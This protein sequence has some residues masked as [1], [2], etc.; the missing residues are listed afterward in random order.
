MKRVFLIALAA[1]S[2]E[3]RDGVITGNPDATVDLALIHYTSDAPFE[4]GADVLI[5]GTPGAVAPPGGRVRLTPPVGEAVEVTPNAAGG[6]VAIVWATLGDSL[7]ITYEHAD[8]EAEATL[9]LANDVRFVGVSAMDPLVPEPPVDGIV[10][11]DFA[12]FGIS[13]Q[14]HVAFNVDNDA[15]V[16]AS[17]SELRVSLAASSADVVC[18]FGLSSTLGPTARECEQVP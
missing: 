14:P 12:H 8:G 13:Q 10:T 9:V 2:P 18:A 3:P 7:A 16:F 15:T 17:D 4:D 11:V 1:C 6:F 5:V